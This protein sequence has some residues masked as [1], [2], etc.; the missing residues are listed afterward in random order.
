MGEKD[1][2]KKFPEK[3]NN[4]DYEFKKD[5][6]LVDLRGDKTYNYFIVDSVITMNSKRYFIESLNDEEMVLSEV[7]EEEGLTRDTY[8]YK[9]VY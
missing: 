3:G 2:V 8:T 9:R 6:E 7:P 1:I 4:A 5:G